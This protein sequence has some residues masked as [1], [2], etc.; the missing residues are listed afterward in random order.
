MNNEDKGDLKDQL[1]PDNAIT[2]V[3]PELENSSSLTQL[4]S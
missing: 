3:S 2:E 4:Q 1:F